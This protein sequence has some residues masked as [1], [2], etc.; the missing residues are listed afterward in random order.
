M[1]VSD[2]E[3][4]ACAQIAL[5][6]H[7]TPKVRSISMDIDAPNKVILFRVYTDGAL[8]ESALEALYCAVTEI[9]AALGGEIRDEYIVLPE[10]EPMKH[11]RL[12]VYARC[13]DTWGDRGA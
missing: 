9:H 7:I 4:R 6:T 13:E 11:L 12:V 2:I 8:H 5:T 10:P 3:L 1:S